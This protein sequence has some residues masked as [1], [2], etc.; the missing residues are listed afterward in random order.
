MTI[1]ELEK[2]LTDLIGHVTFCYN[3]YSCGI[4]PLACDSFDV[5]YGDNEMTVGSVE[6]VL[7]E[8]LFDG[9]ALKDIW[10]D[11]TDLEF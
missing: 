11:V 4:D 3:G 5:W 1:L 2:H 10:D 6:E 7:T 8:E 9:K